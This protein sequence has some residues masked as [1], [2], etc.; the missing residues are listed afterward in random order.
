VVYATF[1]EP[2]E[3]QVRVAEMALER[4]MRMVEQKKDV[5]I[6]ADSLTRLSRASN[7]IAPQT[8]RTLSGGLAAGALNKPKKF[9]GA[10]RNTREGGSLTILFT[11][12]PAPG[13][14]LDQAVAQEFQGTSNMNCTLLQPSGKDKAPFLQP[15][16][17]GT[18]HDEW[19]LTEEEAALASALR[20]AAAGL[21]PQEA[22]E[23]LNALAEASEPNEA[24]LNALETRAE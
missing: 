21:T 3:N 14:E 11:S 18:V 7:A 1:D 23:R 19:L 13:S 6:L 17:C 10:A 16:D 5:I 12:F 9:F 4:A 24:L 20:D 22:A 8:A 15:L 2:P